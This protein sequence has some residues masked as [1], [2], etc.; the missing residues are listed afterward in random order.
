MPAV[1]P[2]PSLADLL[3]DWRQVSPRSPGSRL[4]FP[5]RNGSAVLANFF[6]PAKGV[7]L[8]PLPFKSGTAL[9]LISANSA[10]FATVAAA[11][12]AIGQEPTTRDRFC[13][14]RR[15]DFIAFYEKYTGSC[16]QES[17][18]LSE[19]DADSA[20]FWLGDPSTKR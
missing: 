16:N 13:E 19:I 20:Y 1:R 12:H 6:G 2:E 15:K 8:L 5:Y 9:D 7:Y 17:R 18:A 3:Q 4:G 14:S 10:E 11:F